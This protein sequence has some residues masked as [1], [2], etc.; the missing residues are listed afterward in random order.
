[1]LTFQTSLL[2]RFIDRSL[3][4]EAPCQLGQ[5][6]PSFSSNHQPSAISLEHGSPASIPFWLCF[7]YWWKR[8]R[9][10]QSDTP[11]NLKSYLAGQQFMHCALTLS[12]NT[13]TLAFGTCFWICPQMLW[14]KYL[15]EIY[16]SLRIGEIHLMTRVPPKRP[17]R[18][19]DGGERTEP[20]R[21]GAEHR[22]PPLGDSEGGPDLFTSSKGVRLLHRV[23]I[24]VLLRSLR[25]ARS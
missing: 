9:S 21:L 24:H 5:T 7:N 12:S 20:P 1:M 25:D 23:V 18:I 19:N 17:F 3:V 14:L 6:F 16:T 13:T 8:K 22:D 4:C 15:K 11:I 2:G 10:T